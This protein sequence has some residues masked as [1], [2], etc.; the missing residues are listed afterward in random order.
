MGLQQKKW[1]VTIHIGG[2][3]EDFL[4]LPGGFNFQQAAKLLQLPP[5]SLSSGAPQFLHGM[6]Q[7]WGS[8]KVFF[9]FTIMGH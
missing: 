9:F 6:S 4:L 7:G 1:E 2:F 3:A 8:V 5:T